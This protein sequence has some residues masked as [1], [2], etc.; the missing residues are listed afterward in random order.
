MAERQPLSKIVYPLRNG[1]ITIPAEFRRRLGIGPETLLRLTLAGNELRLAPVR[2]TDTA[3]GWLKE[4]YDTFAP[5]RQEA[6]EQGYSDEELH[7]TI[8]EAVRRVRGNDADRRL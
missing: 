4:L 6:S 7:D 5:V 1:Q 2:T 3:S 8:N